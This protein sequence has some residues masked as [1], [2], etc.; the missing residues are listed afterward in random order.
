M[1]WI[2]FLL[3]FLPP[4]TAHAIALLGLKVYQSLRKRFGKSP[5]IYQVSLSIPP[6][7]QLAFSSRLGLAAGFDK[8]AE[9]FPALGFLGFGFVEVGTVTPLPQR[10]NPKPRI[11]RVGSQSLVNQM[12]F[13]SVGLREFKNNIQKNRRFSQVPVFANVGKN[14]NTEPEKALNDYH[15]CIEALEDCVDGFVINI[16]SP[17][18]PALRDLQNTR[19][20]E[21]LKSVLSKE[22]PTWIK[23]APELSS[24]EFV[25]LIEFIKEDPLLAGVVLHNTSSELALERGFERGGLSG[26]PLFSRTLERVEE[27]ASILRGKKTL[28]GVGGI[29]S[30]KD[31][32]KMKS[33]GADLIE[34]YTSFIYQGPKLVREISSSLK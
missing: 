24:S 14:K 20:L 26:P 23:L 10:G 18:T 25:E 17:N 31:A 4:E 19:F 32:I 11:W 6:K 28:V 16:S 8:Q 9:V 22:K 7:F 3:R 30:V 5:T 13:N 1:A 15:T 21:S 33:C 12:G 2:S 29:S 27:A 34:I